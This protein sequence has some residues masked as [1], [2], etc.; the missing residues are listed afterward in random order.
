MPITHENEL[1]AW[2]FIAGMRLTAGKSP[3]EAISG[4]DRVMEECKK[5]MQEGDMTWQRT[6][7]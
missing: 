4:A 3:D 1:L 2:L 6:N 7:E 5:R